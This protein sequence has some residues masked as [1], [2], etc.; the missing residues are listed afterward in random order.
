M[1]LCMCVYLYMIKSVFGIIFFLFF[2][3]QLYLLLADVFLSI[4]SSHPA[5]VCACV[6]V[7]VCVREDDDDDEENDTIIVHCTCILV[8]QETCVLRKAI[9]FESSQVKPS[10]IDSIWNIKLHRSREQ[11]IYIY[12]YIYRLKYTVH[13]MK[14][15]QYQYHHHHYHH[16]HHSM[17]YVLHVESDVLFV[18]MSCRIPSCRVVVCIRKK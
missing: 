2:L 4:S 12:I 17:N 3:Y 9:I 1:W 16:W 15:K 11:M 8:I 14:K 18:I 10:Q 7:R 6:R 5:C 13:Y